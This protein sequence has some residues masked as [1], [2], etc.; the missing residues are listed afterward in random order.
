MKKII[1]SLIV[2]LGV[3]FTS[4]AQQE[5]MNVLFIA[6][7]DMSSDLNAF[8]N[9]DVYTPNFD[10][11]A[12]RGVVF[13]NAYNQA[14]LCAP[15]RASLMTGYLP[16]KT[17]VYDLYPT[18]RDALPDAVTI[19]QMF[20]NN[21][22]YT[23]R[24]GKIFH[25][26]VPSGIGQPG[27]DDPASWTTTYNPIGK[28]KTDEYKLVADAPMLGTYLAMDCNDGELT[29]AISANV[30]ISILRERTGN[31]TASAYGGY[32]Q[33]RVNPQPF[34]M[35]VGF[36]RPHIPYMAPQKYFDLYPLEKIK[37]RE[38]P[39]NDWD[40]KPH[41][42]AWTLPLNGGATEEQQKKAV[43]AYYACISFVDAQI[44]KLLDGLEEF[45]LLDNTIIVFWSDHGYNLGE[46]GQWQKQTLFEKSS[47]QPLLISV[48][49]MPKG[50]A[51]DAIVQ[52]VDIYPTLADISGFDAPSDLAGH[53]LVP[54][55]KDPDT[56]W[57]Y[58]AFTLQARTVNP[59]P[60][61]GG[62]KYSF[63]PR[64]DSQNPT[65][66]GRSVR[67]K[68]YRYTE[69]DEGR[70]GAELYDYEKDP[71]EFKN[72]ADSPDYQ[73]IRKKLAEILRTNFSN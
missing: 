43:Q 23:C 48:P 2:L 32:M 54:L 21:G 73:N 14:P 13:N 35:A 61:E 65:I 16:D 15:S 60:R 59:R 11:L 3:S 39:K 66:F 62:S 45:G 53:S 55:L 17:G 27:H 67:V 30:A 19:A 9:P 44:G 46:H 4:V 37:L 71:K 69:W 40:N 6:S 1:I 8:G 29:D 47:K 5:K 68:R 51:T 20:K 28:D 12:E 22:Y 63:N 7:D 24:I 57:D 26:G 36:Y 64:V 70:L 33:G 34:F 49:G 56:K 58:P 50:T 42:A 72:L 10:K 52:M 18:F 41:A 31:A 38:N 25:Q